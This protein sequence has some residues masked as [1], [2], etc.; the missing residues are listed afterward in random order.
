MSDSSFSRMI[1]NWLNVEPKK[2]SLS[3]YIMGYWLTLSC[4]SPLIIFL[5]IAV[6]EMKGEVFNK[7][8]VF[9]LL[10]SLYVSFCIQAC[11]NLKIFPRWEWF[12]KL[13]ILPFR[14]FTWLLAEMLTK[15]LAILATLSKFIGTV[16]SKFIGT[17][18]PKF[19]V[20]LLILVALFVLIGI[21]GILLFGIRQV[22]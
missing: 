2:L 5:L 22:F 9:F 10:V 13:I 20:M 7:T 11:L 6:I 21:F 14:I 17:V 12:C 4:Y 19:I 18:L 1:S 3:Q 16:L 15:T 8:G